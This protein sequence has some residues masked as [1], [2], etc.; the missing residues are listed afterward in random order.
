MGDNAPAP[1]LL[2]LRAPPSENPAGSDA[3][4]P[5][6]GLPSS[7]SRSEPGALLGHPEGGEGQEEGNEEVVDSRPSDADIIAQE[8]AI[9][10]EA[11]EKLEFVG[12][13]VSRRHVAGPGRAC[14]LK[15]MLAAAIAAQLASLAQ[16]P[17]SCARSKG[18]AEGRRVG[19]A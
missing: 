7:S 13:K 10:A 16:P 8:N 4:G 12:D 6:P 3:A 9:R 18:R 15:V 19:G 2:P 17:A 14:A 1:S 5:G 11:A